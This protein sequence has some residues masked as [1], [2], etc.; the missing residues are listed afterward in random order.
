MHARSA[1]QPSNIACELRALFTFCS[2]YPPKIRTIT[3]HAN[4]MRAVA[5]F[6][7]YTLDSITHRGHLARHVSCVRRKISSRPLQKS[8][9]THSI[10]ECISLNSFPVV[11][12][13]AIRIQKSV[14]GAFR[15][16][17]HGMH[18]H[19]DESPRALCENYSQGP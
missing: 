14:I 13:H 7:W 9:R 3:G 12:L 19:D 4:S 6:E 18:H 2:L 16:K 1:H 8:L 5:F 17:R 15:S 11:I 10:V